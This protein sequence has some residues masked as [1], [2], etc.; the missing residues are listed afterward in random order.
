VSKYQ[1]NRTF[2]RDPA[3]RN[4][5]WAGFLAADGNV[6]LNRNTISIDLA[7]KDREHLVQFQ[8]D[9]KGNFRIEDRDRG[10]KG[11]QSRVRIDCLAWKSDLRHNYNI[12]PQK[13]FK[14]QPPTLDH[15]LS[16]CFIAG[17]IDGDGSILENGYIHIVGTQA[18]LC[19]IKD[20]FDLLF[21]S[22][23]TNRQCNVRSVSHSPVSEICIGGH[24]AKRF[25]A[26]IQSCNMPLLKRKWDRI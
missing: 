22:D 9:V 5:Y 2:F 25:G 17:Y 21:P 13:T 26:I 3:I 24:R 7:A 19:W 18:L 14:L 20:Q 8:R 4:T 16:L 12:I 23:Y 11:I 6:A 10:N 15:F 1:F